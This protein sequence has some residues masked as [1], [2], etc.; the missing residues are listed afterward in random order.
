[1]RRGPRPEGRFRDKTCYVV[2][3]SSGIGLEL[4]RALVSRG[5][6]V[7]LLAR[8]AERLRSAADRL[9]AASS[10]QPEISWRSVDVT[11]RTALERVLSEAQSRFGRPDILANCAGFARP[12]E[13]SAISEED[14]DRAM[15]V[16]FVGTWN[17]T[18]VLFPALRANRGTVLNV[19][20]V[21]GL[22]GVYGLT[23]YCAAKFAVTG[24]SEALRQ[25][26]APEGVVVQVLFPPDTDTP[27]YARENETKPAETHAVSG[28]ARL[29]SA[30]RV[31][32]YTLERLGSRRR[33][34]VW[35]IP[36]GM[37]KFAVTIKI[38]APG[39]VWYAIDRSIRR[40]RGTR[41][42]DT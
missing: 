19:A 36:D 40:A 7:L 4:A 33:K 6:R 22:I 18:Q 32:R 3:G 42:R 41:G 11:D 1:M 14:R 8:D 2:G 13:F 30:E 24:F 17:A 12:S 37:S 23:D 15:R 35:I 38:L 31:A 28:A 9:A 34:D 20:S 16:N 5:A 10:V 26:A 25:E 29:M 39:L 21:A 27:G